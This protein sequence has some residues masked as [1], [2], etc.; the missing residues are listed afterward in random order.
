LHH[1]TQ[2]EPGDMVEMDGTQHAKF[3]AFL[4]GLKKPGNS[5]RNTPVLLKSYADFQSNYWKERA[6]DFQS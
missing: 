1:L 5:F 2:D 4:H 6:K 3:T